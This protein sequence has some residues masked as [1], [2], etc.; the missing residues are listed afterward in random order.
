MRINFWM[1]S[2]AAAAA[3]VALAAGA[4]AAEPKL[5]TYLVT[6]WSDAAMKQIA[7][8]FEVMRKV[9]GGFEVVVPETETAAFRVL[10]P[11]AQLLN[12]DLDGA[13]QAMEAGIYDVASMERRLKDFAQRYPD[14]VKLET[15]GT[16]KEGRP[17]YVLTMGK[18]ETRAGFAKPELMITSAT[19]GDETI[20]VEVTLGLID[21]LL[22]GYGTDQRLT[23][24]V[25]NSVIY[26]V[27]AVCVDGYA[28]RSRT[29]EGR[30]PNRDFAYPQ[31]PSRTPATKCTR[32]I[33]GFFNG[34]PNI[35]GT[36]DFHAAASMIMYPW[37]WTYDNLPEPERT[38]F[39][40]VTTHMAEA[41]GFAHGTIAD[42]IYIAVGSSAD[43][44]YWK[45]KAFGTAI[46]VSHNFAPSSP[47][48]AGDIVSEN[49]ESTWRWIEHFTN[50]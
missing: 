20:T 48:E 2:L 8:R 29:V 34:K 40:E 39:D 42:T 47:E 25:D 32:D 46:E 3:T 26:W 23:K 28:N 21:K 37:A 6:P 38:D 4:Q 11:E 7:T 19:H 14:L 12:P 15:Y 16:S 22:K 35:V 33:V 43:Y 45:N 30:D 49:T 1:K 10:A 5:Q 18:K 13:V 31:A 36:M 27:P 41:N 17:E 44:Y 9:A 50:R 24:M